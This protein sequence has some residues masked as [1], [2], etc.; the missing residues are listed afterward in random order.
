MENPNLVVLDGHTL[1]PGDLAWQPLEALA[2]CTVHPRTAPP[3]TVARCRGAELVLTNKVV[4]DRATIEQLPELRYIGVMA[5]GYNVVDVDAARDHEVVVTNVPAYSTRSVAQLVFAHVL[6]LAHRLDHHLHAVRDGRWQDSPDF[7]FWDYPQMELV[8]KVMGIVGFGQIGQATATLA[9]AFGMKVLVHT[10]TQ[11][12]G[13]EV[14]YV[15]LDDLFRRA[16]VVSLHCPLTDQT[17]H[18]VDEYRL[19]LMKKTAFLINTGRGPLID[20]DALDRA[21][22][23]GTIAGAGLD[24]LSSEPPDPNNPLLRARNCGITPHIAWATRAA[25]QRLLDTL[26]QNLSAFLDGN[27]KNVVNT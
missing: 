17:Q 23:S 24:V 10:R 4:L 9:Q 20:E 18:M 13:F 12:P 15:E 5:T 19:G 21:L 1:N 26:V 14:E 8:D 16:D 2:S 7:C 27:P 25:R 22:N 11:R 3:E 6:N